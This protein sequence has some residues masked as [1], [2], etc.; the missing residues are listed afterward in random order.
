MPDSWLGSGGAG[1]PG[2]SYSCSPETWSDGAAGDDRLDPGAARSRSA[3]IGAA[4][5]TCSKLSRTRRRRLSREPVGRAIRSIEPAGALGDA[6]RARDARRDEHRVADRFERHEEDAVREVVATIAPR[7][8]ARAV[9]CRCRPARSAS[10]AGSRPAAA[11]AASSSASRPTN[12]VSWVG[13][14]FGRASS[15][16]SGGKSA[17]R[18]SATTWTIRTGALRSLSRCSPRSR[19]RDA[20]DRVVGELVADQAG[21][22][23]LPAVGQRPRAAPPG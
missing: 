23:D 10:A 17:G 9:S 4:A 20:V 22:E 6:E 5:T 16:R 2:T 8:G 1:R 15:D 13:R 11:A 19:R 12:V 3:T 7:A 21:R 14:L 18:P